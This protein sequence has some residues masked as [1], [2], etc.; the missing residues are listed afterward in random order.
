MG[1]FCINQ[2]EKCIPGTLSRAYTVV[3]FQKVVNVH[4]FMVAPLRNLSSFDLYSYAQFTD[5]YWYN[6]FCTS[7]ATRGN[8]S[9]F[10]AWCLQKIYGVLQQTMHTFPVKNNGVVVI[11]FK[12]LL[13]SHWNYNRVTLKSQLTCITKT[14][15]NYWPLDEN[16]KIIAKKI[17]WECKNAFNWHNLSKLYMNRVTEK[18]KSSASLIAIFRLW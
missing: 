6:L 17:T 1:S 14:T 16:K 7:T 8:F 5:D 9:A 18:S 2:E 12:P 11:S 3:S 10:C 4:Y 15:I 13:I